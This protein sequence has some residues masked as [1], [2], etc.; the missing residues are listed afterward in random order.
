MDFYM[1]PI[2]YFSSDY[3]VGSV[4]RI[5]FQC[6]GQD[7]MILMW[8]GRYGF[9]LLGGEIGVFTKPFAQ[10]QYVTAS[11]GL[12]MEMDVYQHNFLTR[13]T[14]HLFTRG[15]ASEWRYNGFV[16]GEFYEPNRKDEIIM[17]G[18]I[19]F[20]D[21]EMLDAFEAPFAAA[22]F[23]KGR[24]TPDPSHPETYSVSGNTLIFSWQYIDQDA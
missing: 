5:E 24:R 16:P 22:G 8:K 9:V 17:V 12:Q 4:V 7:R 10:K 1:D 18:S 3:M 21:Q 15:P 20:P 11:R 6:D 19:T 14:A 13:K 23:V 2:P